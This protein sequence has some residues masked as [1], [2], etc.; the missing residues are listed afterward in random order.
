MLLYC[1]IIQVFEIYNNK[2]TS[3]N[4]PRWKDVFPPTS[5]IKGGTLFS[6]YIEYENLFLTV[7]VNK[8]VTTG[9]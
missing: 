4:V 1:D 2:K 9:R 3:P 6:L 7:L 5:E 8:Y